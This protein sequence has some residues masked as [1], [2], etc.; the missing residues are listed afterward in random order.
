MSAIIGASVIALAA[1]IAV[2]SAALIRRPGAS[3]LVRG[4]FVAM[5]L[6][7]LITAVLSSGVTLMA[8]EAKA[9]AI[10]YWFTAAAIVVAAVTLFVVGLRYLSDRWQDETA[11]AQVITLPGGQDPAGPMPAGGGAGKQLAA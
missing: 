6:S 4:E 2:L 9:T 11:G 5:A 3:A 10:W 7:L 1:L 8:M